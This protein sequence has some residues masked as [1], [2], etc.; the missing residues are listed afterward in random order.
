MEGTEAGRP[1]DV[2]GRS[3]TVGRGADDTIVV[4]DSS[5]SRRHVRIAADRRSVTLED[6]GLVNSV[7][8]NGQRVRRAELESGDLVVLS[9]RVSF[10][11]QRVSSAHLGL[12][13]HLYDSSTRDRL[14]GA[15]CK[16]HY[17]DHLA[18]EVA[19]CRRHGTDLG[20]VLLD[21]DLFRSFN[22]QHGHATGDAV[23][24]HITKDIARQLRTEDLFARIG[25]DDFVILLRG[26][27]T[28]GCLHLAQRLRLSIAAFPIRIDS[29]ALA[30]TLSLG[31]ASLKGTEVTAQALTALAE[32][33]LEQAKGQGGNR[34]VAAD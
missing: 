11:F 27:N 33:R 6:A 22:D 1:Y 3:S 5:I 19:F 28:E 26:I 12:M 4:E 2:T 21:V 29:L 9:A 31:C 32:E 20:L 17:Q 34:V 13:Q 23:L 18:T 25:G 30:V 14:T 7:S 24:Q 10:V 8:V 16:K 15:Y